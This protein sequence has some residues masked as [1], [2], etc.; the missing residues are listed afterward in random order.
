MPETAVESHPFRKVRE[1]D[2]APGWTS[3]ADRV[4]GYFEFLITKAPRKTIP[5]QKPKATKRPVTFSILR[6]KVL[7]VP[8]RCHCRARPK[9][10]KY[11]RAE[12]KLTIKEVTEIMSQLPPF[13]VAAGLLFK[14]AARMTIAP[15]ES[16][17]TCFTKSIFSLVR[18]ISCCRF[19]ST[20]G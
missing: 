8:S 3:P 19:C 1:K 16:V 5:E 4:V 10:Q 2:G 17:E 11:T 15:L 6:E 18:S 12:T 13:G 7:G 9:A 14:K 20:V